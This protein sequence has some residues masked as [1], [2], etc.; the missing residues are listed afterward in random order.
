MEKQSIWNS[1]VQQILNV[2]PTC[3]LEAVLDKLSVR[4][5]VKYRDER[6]GIYTEF[7]AGR[8]QS[9]CTKGEVIKRI[10]DYFENLYKM[11]QTVITM[12]PEVIVNEKGGKQHKVAY[13]LDLIPPNVLLAI[14][15]V[16]DEGAHRYGEWNWLKIPVQDHL[17]HA[18]IHIQQHLN[19][20]R[21]EPHLVHALCRLTFAQ[22]LTYVAENSVLGS[23]RFPSA[24]HPDTDSQKF[25][26]SGF[27]QTSTGS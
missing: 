16:L 17:N 4:D 19:N 22:H 26:T 25:Q 9:E 8:K 3:P 20:D 6:N 27:L 23:Q 15:Q 5:H 21:S 11:A 2:S 12:E 13:R 7:I 14:G 24:G 18:M 10:N 1:F